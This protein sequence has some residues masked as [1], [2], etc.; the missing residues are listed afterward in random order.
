MRSWFA[1]GLCLPSNGVD[2]CI[3]RYNFSSWIYNTL[4]SDYRTSLCEKTLLL[5]YQDN[6]EPYRVIQSLSSPA[7]GNLH[8]DLR[9]AQIRVQHDTNA[10]AILFLL[11]Y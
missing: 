8:L 11:L 2:Q 7:F 1:E 5:Q 6:R 9:Y 4:I 10:I 3:D